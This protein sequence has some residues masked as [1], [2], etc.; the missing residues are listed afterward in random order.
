MERERE[1]GEKMGNEKKSD[2]REWYD[3]TRN[4]SG[5]VEIDPLIVLICGLILITMENRFC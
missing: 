1:E 5:E 3:R 4:E 2:T